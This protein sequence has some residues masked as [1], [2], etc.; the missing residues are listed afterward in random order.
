MR[1]S[2]TNLFGPDASARALQ[3][4]QVCVCVFKAVSGSFFSLPVCVP[5][6][7]SVC[8]VLPFAMPWLRMLSPHCCPTYIVANF[9]SQDGSHNNHQTAGDCDTDGD[10]CD[11]DLCHIMS[12]DCSTSRWPRWPC[13]PSRARRALVARVVVAWACCAACSWAAWVVARARHSL[14]LWMP[15]PALL[16]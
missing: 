13:P 16:G 9:D 8:H 10:D 6:C 7:E 1:S 14:T 15:T 5:V 4:T 3:Y 12:R 11:A 2:M